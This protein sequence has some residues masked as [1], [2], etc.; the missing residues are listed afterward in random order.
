MAELLPERLGSS[1]APP[2]SHSEEDKPPAK[3]KRKQVTNILEWVQCFN[4]YIAVISTKSPSRVRDLLGYQTLIIQ[5]SMEYRG[6]GWLGYDRRFRQNAAADPDT[7]WAR[8]DPTLWNIA[9]A[10]QGSATRCS[11]CFSLTHH[12]SECEW[13]P[14]TPKSVQTSTSAALTPPSIP[15][16]INPL[17][18]PVCFEWNYNRSPVCLHPNC[19]YQHMCA[20]CINDPT[21][22]NKAHKALFCPR[23]QRPAIQQAYP[24]QR[25]SRPRFQPY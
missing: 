12:S 15:K 20:Y 3:P 4:I 6:D 25:A 24:P 14:P 1:T 7:V 18:Q 23:R 22:A 13:A 5:A 19:R 10:G 11:Y 17:N 9:F 8:L 16:R 21:M 2:T